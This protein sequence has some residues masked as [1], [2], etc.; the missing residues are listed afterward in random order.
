M[1]NI[2]RQLYLMLGLFTQAIYAQ[3]LLFIQEGELS[4]LGETNLY[5][6]GGIVIEGDGTLR[7][8]G[9]VYVGTN[10]SGYQP[11]VANWTQNDLG[12]L[13]GNS[14]IIEFTGRGITHL[15][16]GDAEIMFPALHIKSQALMQIPVKVNQLLI[17]DAMLDL[18]SQSLFIDNPSSRSLLHRGQNGGIV[19]ETHPDRDGAYGQVSWN[20]AGADPDSLYTI[21]LSTENGVFLPIS[22]RLGSR[23][24]D[25][26]HVATYP[27]NPENK[28]YPS[29]VD[30][31]RDVEHM[32]GPNGED[33][34]SDFLDR[35]WL[36]NGEENELTYL[37]LAYDPEN[38]ISGNVIGNEARLRVQEWTSAKW[39]FF[40]WGDEINDNSIAWR[41]SNILPNI[42]SASLASEIAV[43]SIPNLTQANINRIEV[44][45]NPGN[46]L[47]NLST[48]YEN[49]QSVK[50]TVFD[51]QGKLLFRSDRPPHAIKDQYSIDLTS[52]P[53]GMYFMYVQLH[54]HRLSY[55]L[56]KQ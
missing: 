46:G 16:Q 4:L 38:D 39:T 13:L 5:V 9:S 1:K 25:T 36:V 15:I 17:E 33:I 37:S 45:P 48:E 6:E 31:L 8:E 19:S 11:T 44:F 43:S 54:G 10:G 51:L 3:D 35:F 20:L 40:D 30:F 50:V 29:Q 14:G 22:F 55:R 52:Y 56:I 41:E 34:S 23:G 12:A 27:T 2:I 7:S 49:P 26:I 24:T 47:F 28:P 32:R 21:P 42:Y 18:N 53:N